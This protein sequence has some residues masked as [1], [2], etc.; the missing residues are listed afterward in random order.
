MENPSDVDVVDVAGALCPFQACSEK[1]LESTEPLSRE[2]NPADRIFSTPG[3]QNSVLGGARSHD[4]RNLAALQ[5]KA[6]GRGPKFGAELDLVS[7]CF[8]T[9][10]TS[11]RQGLGRRW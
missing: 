9:S 8:C 6:E 10:L 3:P 2:S 7:R 1:T 4:C 11:H 5:F